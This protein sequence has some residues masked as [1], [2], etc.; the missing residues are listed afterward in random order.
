MPGVNGSVIVYLTLII[1]Q[2]CFFS[3]SWSILFLHAISGEWPV[4]SILS[5]VSQYPHVCSGIVI[6]MHDCTIRICRVH[7][8][9]VTEYTNVSR[10]HTT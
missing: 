3:K 5:G 7:N 2:V 1:V 4:S 9:V 6:H 10:L 8:K